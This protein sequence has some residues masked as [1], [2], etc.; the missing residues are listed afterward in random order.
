MTP[1][2]W[3]TVTEKVKSVGGVWPI[4]TAL[5]SFCLYFLGYL[6]LRFQLSAWGVATDLAALDERYF[7]AGARF[8]VY[9]VSSAVNAL[10]LASPLLLAWWLI[11]KTLR[12]QRWRKAANYALLGVIFG[13]LFIQLIER[14]CFQFM[15][16]VLVQQ[17]LEGDDWLKAILLGRSPNYESLFF[18]ALIAGVTASAWLLLEAR[19]RP[20][21][22][23]AVEALLIFLVAVEFLLLPVNYGIIIATREIPRVSQ[24]AP[25]EAWLVWEGKEKT[26]FLVVEGGRKLVSVPNAEVKKLEIT[27]I[28]HIFRRLFPE[29]GR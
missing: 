19:T 13:V 17:Q 3:A 16:S 24:F 23:P 22:R 10:L 1:T 15:N 29:N 20:F 5:G 18:A 27:G 2:A 12:F 26:T 4:Y 7:F 25:A 6:V 28:D 9:L 21:R 11:N 8:L 14:K